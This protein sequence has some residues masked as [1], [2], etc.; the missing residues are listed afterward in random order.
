MSPSR[1]ETTWPV[2]SAA[3]ETEVEMPRWKRSRPRP[4]AFGILVEKRR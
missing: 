4:N 1:T 2:K 3:S